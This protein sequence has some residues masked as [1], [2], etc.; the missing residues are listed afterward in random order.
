M[1][2]SLWT[3]LTNHIPY[4]ISCW[5]N[6]LLRHPLF[7]FFRTTTIILAILGSQYG[8]FGPNDPI[9]IHLTVIKRHPEELCT[10]KDIGLVP[11]K[12][13][14]NVAFTILFL[15]QSCPQPFPFLSHKDDR[16]RGWI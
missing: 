7:A 5:I 3:L 2:K 8:N 4:L 1:D 13:N 9:L 15:Y 11:V 6:F 16:K 12:P 10:P 14:G